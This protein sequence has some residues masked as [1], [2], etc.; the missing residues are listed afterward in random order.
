M[1]IPLH[2]MTIIDGELRRLKGIPDQ[3]SLNEDV[4][5]FLEDAHLWLKLKGICDPRGPFDKSLVQY[6]CRA[7][8]SPTM[9]KWGGNRQTATRLTNALSPELRNLIIQGKA[10]RAS[11]I[12]FESIFSYQ[13]C[14]N[15]VLQICP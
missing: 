8:L 9:E 14:D 2:S 5:D 11:I 3:I 7:P 4:L 10:A 1:G 13:A 6:A 12:A 15:Y